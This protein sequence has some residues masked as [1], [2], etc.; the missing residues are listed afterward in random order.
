MKSIILVFVITVLFLVGMTK[1]TNDTNFN[2]AVRYASL[3]NYLNS[4]NKISYD[5]EGEDDYFNEEELQVEV[6]FKGAVNSEKKITIKVG[7]YLS[8]ALM[9]AGGLASDADTRCINDYYVILES[10]DFYIPRGKDI[11]KV[12]INTALEVELMSLPSIG[13]TIASRI[14]DY[15]KTNGNYG[16]LED[17]LNVKGVGNATFDKFKDYIIL[18]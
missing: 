10:M 4:I 6:S 11:E 18:W 2:E 8:S 3:S 12:S 7:T 5:A 15:R 13:S 16:C 14:V 9:E 1:F 17:L